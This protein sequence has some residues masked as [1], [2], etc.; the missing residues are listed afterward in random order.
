M[1]KS[2]LALSLAASSLLMSCNTFNNYY[3]LSYQ[4]GKDLYSF[5]LDV[6]KDTEYIFD[7]DLSKYLGDKKESMATLFLPKDKIYESKAKVYRNGELLKSGDESSFDYQ[8]E[9]NGIKL[10]SEILFKNKENPTFD[11]FITFNQDVKNINII[12]GNSAN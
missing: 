10:N 9:D 7:V 11:F 2:L 8:I 6:V 5:T 3:A 4:K 12:F 1:K